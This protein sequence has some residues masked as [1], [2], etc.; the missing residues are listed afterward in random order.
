MKTLN[1]QDTES[2]LGRFYQVLEDKFAPYYFGEYPKI[3]QK[4]H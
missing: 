1:N 4:L 2:I 3:Y